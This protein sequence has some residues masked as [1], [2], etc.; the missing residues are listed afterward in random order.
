MRF[1]AKLTRRLNQVHAAAAKAAAEKALAGESIADDLIRLKEYEALLDLSRTPK[2]NSLIGAAMVG[3]A[4]LLLAGLAWAV[5]IPN[6]NLH[7]TVVTDA[8]TFGL[9]ESWHW[10]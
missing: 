4:C 9:T 5:R 8:L 10:T 7:V 2:R 6:T 3:T 1:P